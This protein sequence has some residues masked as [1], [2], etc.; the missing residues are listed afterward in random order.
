MHKVFAVILT[1]NRKGLLKRCLDAV[2]SQSWPCDC[3][4]IIDNASND[5]TEKMLSEGDYPGLIV[6]VLKD[7]I[8]ASGGYN[9]GLRLAY[10]KGADFIW[11]MDDDVIPEKDALHYL[12]KAD[13]E[14]KKKEKKAA[15]LISKAL[16]ETG[17]ATN[18]PAVS[19][20]KNRIGYQDWPDILEL[21]MV[22]VQRSTFVS[23]LLPRATLAEYGLPITA[24]FI[25]GED[26]E[27]TLRVT[28]KT[29]GYLVGLSKVNHLR[30][31]DGPISI[32]TES[33]P[34]RLKLYRY[35][36]R[37]KLFISRKY[38]RFTFS[39]YGMISEFFRASRLFF[40]LLFKRRFNKAGIV[41]RGIIES[42]WFFPEPE[43]A[44][45]PNEKMKT[46]MRLLEQHRKEKA[47]IN[48]EKQGEISFRMGR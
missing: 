42:I 46:T 47:D 39:R 30:Q 2:Y 18:T 20:L 15:F 38:Y 16:T 5:G 28:Q 29:P 22:A 19:T 24:M 25:W 33:N 3:V 17:L 9:A 43:S 36:I 13:D 31:E 37:N 48:E 6:S 40:T 35:F 27:F 32:L 44:D 23:I 1:Y 26:T 21:G 11:A 12:M 45:T 8:G 14:L 41:L 7:N 10:Q 4:I 34:G